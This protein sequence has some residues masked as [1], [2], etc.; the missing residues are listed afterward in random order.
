MHNY[1]VNIVD[2]Q[3]GIVAYSDS[4]LPCPICQR[5]TNLV[6]KVGDSK[7]LACSKECANERDNRR[8]TER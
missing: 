7:Y 1:H 2:R 5:P 6:Y 4:V 3:Q 8:N